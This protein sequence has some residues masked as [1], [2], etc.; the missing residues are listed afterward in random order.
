MIL[1]KSFFEIITRYLVLTA[2]F[3]KCSIFWDITPC[4]LLKVDRRFGKICHLNLRSRRISQATTV[5]YQWTT[6]RYILQGR[7]LDKIMKWNCSLPVIPL[8]HSLI[9]VSSS[10]NT[11]S[12]IKVFNHARIYFQKPWTNIYEIMEN[13]IHGRSKI[14]CKLWLFSSFQYKSPKSD[15]KKICSAV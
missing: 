6:R 14:G 15:L 8:S 5:E 13:Y 7:T 9:D 12:N 2:V 10:E 4:N 3:E 11:A 1:R